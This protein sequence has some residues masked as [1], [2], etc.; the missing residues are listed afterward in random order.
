MLSPAWETGGQG[1]HPLLYLSYRLK[2]SAPRWREG[3]G[4][5]SR[6]PRHP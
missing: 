1:S 3:A 4:I 2:R 6:S 5:V